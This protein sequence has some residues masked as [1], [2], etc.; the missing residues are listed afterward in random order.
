MPSGLSAVPCRHGDTAVLQ[1]DFSLRGITNHLPSGTG[2][3]EVRGRGRSTE[4][5]VCVGGEAPLSSGDQ[6]PLEPL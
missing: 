3:E 2:R 6:G 5:Q 4:L 1:I